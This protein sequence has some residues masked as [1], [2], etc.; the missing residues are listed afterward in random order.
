MSGGLWPICEAAQADY[1]Q[2]REIVLAGGALGDI[3]AARR[4]ARE[5]LAGLIS[6][7]VAE[8]SYLASVI[9]AGRPPWCGCEDPR[10]QQLRDVYGF[11]LASRD[12]Y[13]LRAVSK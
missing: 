12:S 4:F 8:P 10:E 13:S 11:L 3:L 5:G 2:L 1:E 6:S 9:A 7:P